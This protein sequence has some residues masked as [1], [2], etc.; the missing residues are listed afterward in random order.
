MTQ[1]DALCQKARLDLSVGLTAEGLAEHAAQCEA[2]RLWLADV[3]RLE[4]Q[5]AEWRADPPPE[6]LAARIAE[7]LVRSSRPS[8]RSDLFKWKENPKMR[9]LS[10]ALAVAAVAICALFFFVNGQAATAYE[11]MALA[12]SRVKSAHM[13]VWYNTAKTGPVHI[14]KVEEVWYR[15]HNWRK[16]YGER[17]DNDR[18]VRGSTYYAYDPAQ[19]KVVASRENAPQV[20]DF[21]LAALA[22]DYMPV[23]AKPH[24]HLVR[25]MNENGK[26][27]QEIDLDLSGQG[28]RMLFWVDASTGLPIRAEKQDMDYATGRWTING[29]F[30]FEFN[31][32]LPASLFDPKSLLP[33]SRPTA[34]IP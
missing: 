21:S 13:I 3:N 31:R 27:I 16:R 32:P 34:P 26:S 8:R 11:R 23:G 15:G 1:S 18:I 29:R 7:E 25:T 30:E 2:C 17:T 19:R 22:G 10:Y 6:N 9:R 14:Q 20:T 5:L 12:V 4:A 33:A 24:A 28:E